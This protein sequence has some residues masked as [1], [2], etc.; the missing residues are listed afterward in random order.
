MSVSAGLQE[1]LGGPM[2]STAAVAIGVEHFT[3]SL[4]DIS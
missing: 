3:S 4:H 1:L 2:T